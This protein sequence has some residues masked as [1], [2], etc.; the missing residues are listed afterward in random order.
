MNLIGRK[1]IKSERIGMVKPHENHNQYALEE[2][3]KGKRIHYHTFEMNLQ[4]LACGSLATFSNSNFRGCVVEKENFTVSQL[5]TDR[6]FSNWICDPPVSCRLGSK[7]SGNLCFIDDIPEVHDSA[8]TVGRSVHRTNA[9]NPILC[10]L[11]T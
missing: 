1:S 2:N 10:L 3:M 5:A 9:Q 6:R 4:T 7:S 8:S 11:V